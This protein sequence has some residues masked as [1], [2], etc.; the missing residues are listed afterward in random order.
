MPAWPSSLRL[1]LTLWY[2]ALLAVPLI[3]FA[4]ICYVFVAQ[5]LLARTDRFIGD[6]LTAFSREIVAERR[7]AT[8]AR[9][10]I[11]TTVNEV[12]FRD[13][14]IAVLDSS[15]HVVAAT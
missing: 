11:R 7:M 1:R 15:R 8:T 12:R 10:A 5:A 2:S 13:L 3:A 14:H 9:D 4:I 6:A